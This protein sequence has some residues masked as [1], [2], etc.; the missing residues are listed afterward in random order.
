LKKT[1][2][3]ARAVDVIF[4]VFFS[5]SVVVIF[6]FCLAYAFKKYDE[7]DYKSGSLFI[8]LAG[9]SLLFLAA[10]NNRETV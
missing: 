10:Y 4:D 8:V 7:K 3:G 5:I 2:C 9:Y 1:T 6:F